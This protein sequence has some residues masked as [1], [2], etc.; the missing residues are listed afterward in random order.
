MDFAESST[1]CET[2]PMS[3]GCFVC[4]DERGWNNNPLVYCD[5][6]L[7]SVA[8]HQA[9]YGIVSVPKGPWYC[10]ACEAGKQANNIKCCLCPFK[11][12]ALKSTIDGRW[13][14]VVCALYI[15]EVVFKNVTTMEPVLTREVPFEKFV[16]GCYICQETIKEDESKQGAC[17]TCERSGCKLGFHVTC[18]Q[19]RG[20]LCEITV[21]SA[22]KYC[23]YCEHH[24]SKC[25]KR[26]VVSDEM[27]SKLYI[28]ALKKEESL[29]KKENSDSHL[30]CSEV[31]NETL[32]S[33]VM[34]KVEADSS[35]PA[36]NDSAVLDENSKKVKEVDVVTLQQAITNEIPKNA[37]TPHSAQSYSN[38]DLDTVA[39]NTLSG[40]LPKSGQ[41]AMSK[42]ASRKSASKSGKSKVISEK[43]KSNKKSVNKSVKVSR[44]KSRPENKH[45]KNAD[46]NEE[47]GKSK[48]P[49]KRGPKTKTPQNQEEFVLSP[50]H[51]FVSLASFGEA[52]L[53]ASE[54]SSIGILKPTPHTQ[55]AK[56]DIITSIDSTFK[57]Q[58]EDYYDFVAKGMNQ[59]DACVLR[60]TLE[61]RKGNER[62]EAFIDDLK[63]RIDSL[64]AL[65]KFLNR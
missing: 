46:D 56:V 65:Q 61:C 36:S 17:M 52:S 25:K 13:A 30:K 64:L 37:T 35:L 12:G 20:L 7:C 39:A 1:N 24:I 47:T 11:G 18:G 15:P 48:S 58:Q 45:S 50:R 29:D 54:P 42:A 31:G 21:S 9:C 27:F 63:Q 41:S 23:G 22:T 28:R 8:V 55:S 5:G 60:S 14:H 3:G 6:E 53:Q 38:T 16:Q 51:S 49:S 19:M 62:R 43:S 40:P 33:E 10:R 44:S 26:H 34:T 2:K 57:K 32:T 59:E 4:L